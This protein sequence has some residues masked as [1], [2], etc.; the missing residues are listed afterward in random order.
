MPTMTSRERAHVEMLARDMHP[1]L[2]QETPESP[3]VR[4]L[5][6]RYE[7]IDHLD[8][9]RRLAVVDGF[10]FDKVIGNNIYVSITVH[11]YTSER[12]KDTGYV[13]EK[14]TLEE[15]RKITQLMKKMGA[16]IE[17]KYQDS[18]FVLHAEL[19][20]GLKLRFIADRGAVCEK[21]VV[22]QKWVEPTQGRFVDVVEYDC[23][24]VSL[25]RSGDV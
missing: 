17:K 1:D 8:D 5:R 9:L 22:G 25:L 2:Y 13:D 16:K 14:A 24:P 6:K 12:Y 10:P 21:K 23:N 11:D 18:N 20:S 4:E 3:E 15:L 7:K 19:P